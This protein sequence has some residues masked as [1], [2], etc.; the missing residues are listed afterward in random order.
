MIISGNI[1]TFPPVGMCIGQTQPRKEADLILTTQCLDS[2]GLCILVFTLGGIVMV[3]TRSPV[4]EKDIT[5]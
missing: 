2:T 4:I 5:V 3:T 1:P